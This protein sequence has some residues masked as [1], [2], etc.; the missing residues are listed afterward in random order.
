MLGKSAKGYR[1]QGQIQMFS[2]T[3]GH[4]KHTILSVGQR[5]DYGAVL[6]AVA[7]QTHKALL[8]GSW[9]TFRG[10]G[11]LLV[12]IFGICTSLLMIFFVAGPTCTGR[13]VQHVCCSFEQHKTNFHDLSACRAGISSMNFKV[14]PSKKIYEAPG[15]E[16]KW[17]TGIQGKEYS[18]FP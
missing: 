9:G 13:F 6:C 5:S 15:N 8:A 17:W 7:G 10:W 16:V 2:V 4:L 11:V 14:F 12:C 1:A 3:E 18:F